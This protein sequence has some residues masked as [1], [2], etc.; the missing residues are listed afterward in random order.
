MNAPRLNNIC[1]AV[2][3]HFLF[4]YKYLSVLSEFSITSRHSIAYPA[5]WCRINIEA[6]IMDFA[7]KI[8]VSV[9]LLPFT[10]YTISGNYLT[11]QFPHLKYLDTD[12]VYFLRMSFA[13]NEFFCVNHFNAECLTKY[14]SHESSLFFL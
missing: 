4:S 10:N 9:L 13:L 7:V 5:K 14:M 12:S 11:S 2:F 6:K 1:K 8:W 3:C